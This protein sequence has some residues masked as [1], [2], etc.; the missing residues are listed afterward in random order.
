MLNMIELE[1]VI[2]ELSF[3][4]NLSCIM[5]GFGKDVNPVSKEKFL[6]FENYKRILEKISNVRLGFCLCYYFLIFDNIV[7]V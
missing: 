4:C 5:C 2:V 6:S 7:P 3:N 1:E